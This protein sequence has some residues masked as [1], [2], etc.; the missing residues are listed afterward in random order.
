MKR[1]A[2]NAI[3]TITL[4][5]KDWSGMAVSRCGVVLA[6]H[7]DLTTDL[8]VNSHYLTVDLLLNFSTYICSLTRWIL[9][10]LKP[11]KWS[12][13]KV[14]WS[15]FGPKIGGAMRRA[16]S[17][18]RVGRSQE[19]QQEVWIGEIPKFAIQ[20]NSG[21]CL[22]SNLPFRE[23]TLGPHLHF[24]SQLRGFDLPKPGCDLQI[25]YGSSGKLSDSGRW[26]WG[27][28]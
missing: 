5:G 20:R 1:L 27:N 17:R 6:N 9:M 28:F 23:D 7:T 15:P 21:N 16:G 22:S 18:L 14:I 10:S 26:T 24:S 8:I 11:Q 12:L 3:S 2:T 4:G 19:L 25:W 13:K